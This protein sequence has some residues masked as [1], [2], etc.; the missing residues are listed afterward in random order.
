MLLRAAGAGDELAVAD[1]HVRSWRVAYRGL[2]PAEYLAG[3]DPRQR[4]ARYTFTDPDAVTPSTTVAVDEGAICGFATVGPS[5]DSD[6][7]GAGELYA[8][9]VDP[10]CW[11]RGLGRAL[12]DDARSRLASG[13]YAQAC[14]WVL[15][16][17]TRSRSFYR[18]DGWL[19]DGG[20]RVE[21]IGWAG[22]EELRYQRH[23]P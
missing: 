15:A 17:N 4:A 16:A 20:L 14:L 9:Y 22:V 10:N 18:A 6:A 3:L 1:V 2:L 7:H 8:I 21:N 19:P 11:H 23:I 13:G 5:R 12:I